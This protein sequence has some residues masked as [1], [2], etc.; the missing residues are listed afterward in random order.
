MGIICPLTSSE[1]GCDFYR[2]ASKHTAEFLAFVQVSFC[3]LDFFFLKLY[4]YIHTHVYFQ[5]AQNLLKTSV[6]KLE[7]PHEMEMVSK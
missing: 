3:I 5:L 7:L 4:I 6:K 1:Q 2:T